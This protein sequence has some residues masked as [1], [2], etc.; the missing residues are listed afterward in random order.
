M[1]AKECRVSHYKWWDSNISY[2][3]AN[4]WNE[5]FLDMSPKVSW[6]KNNCILRISWKPTAAPHKSVMWIYHCHQDNWVE[7]LR[8]MVPFACLKSSRWAFHGNM[9]AI[10]GCPA[11]RKLPKFLHVKNLLFCELTLSHSR[12]DPPGLDRLPDRLRRQLR[13]LVQKFLKWYR[14]NLL[15][16][17]CTDKLQPSVL[18]LSVIPLQF[19]E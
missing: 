10:Y 7:I 11:A 18:A 9:T 17:V 15:C 12:N 4:Y 2:G 6:S 3:F 5:A 8:I 1:F 16:L 14:D 19:A 13:L